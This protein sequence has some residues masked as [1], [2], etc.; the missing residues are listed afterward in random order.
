[1]CTESTVTQTDCHQGQA[2]TIEEGHHY[3]VMGIDV[4]IIQSL[5]AAIQK[6]VQLN[7]GTF[8]KN[9]NVGNVLQRN[10]ASMLA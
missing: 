10:T 5:S 9:C 2:G 8:R 4:S 1:M 6:P 7:Q 3:K